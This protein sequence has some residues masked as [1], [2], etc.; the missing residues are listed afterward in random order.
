MDVDLPFELKALEGALHVAVAA[1]EADTLQ[2]EHSIGASLDR[3]DLRVSLSVHFTPKT[4]NVA[5][6]C[7]AMHK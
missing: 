1:V 5:R 3:L 7:L 2:L 4:T 6:V